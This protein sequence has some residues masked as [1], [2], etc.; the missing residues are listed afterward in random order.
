[1]GYPARVGKGQ[2]RPDGSYDYIC[3][4]CRDSGVVDGSECVWCYGKD[5][6]RILD[7]MHKGAR[8]QRYYALLK[9]YLSVKGRDIVAAAQW[10]HGGEHKLTV[11]DLG[12][13]HLRFGLN[14]K[15]LTEWLEEC[16]VIRSGV[17]DRLK[18][19]GVRIKDILEAERDA[20]EAESEE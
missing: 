4:A 3:A 7:E 19:N 6:D 2:S 8:G 16:G 10:M 1:M 15:A 9:A 13:L 20:S 17:Y 18:A 11:I 12:H 14:F 5:A